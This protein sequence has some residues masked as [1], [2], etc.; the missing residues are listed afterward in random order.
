MAIMEILKQ[1]KPRRRTSERVDRQFTAFSG[2]KEEIEEAQRYGYSWNQIGN[3]VRSEMQ[4]A[5]TWD[6]TW[7][8]WDVQKIHQMLRRRETER[9]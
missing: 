1:E 5:G 6:E 9:G 4:K 7:S 3:A 8:M 2:Y